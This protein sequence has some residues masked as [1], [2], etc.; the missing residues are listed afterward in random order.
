MS[1][2]N[3]LR[4]VASQFQ[5]YGEVSSIAPHGNGHINETYLVSCRGTNVPT[6]FILQ[7]INRN[8]FRDP[9]AV[10]RNIEHVTAHISAQLDGDPD[11]DRRVLALIP[12][13]A[14]RSSHVDADGETWRAY[15]FIQNTSSFEAA[16]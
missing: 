10:M 1:E 13:H 15:R 5:F 7:R 2:P 4:R 12:T 11:S 9:A 14:G 16:T 6:Q 8:V 3:D